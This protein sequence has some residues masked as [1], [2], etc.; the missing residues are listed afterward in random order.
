MGFFIMKNVLKVV[1]VIIG[2][3]I[4]AGFAS[5]QEVYLFFFSYGM[6]GLIGILISSIII[7]VVIY[8]TFNILN[9][10]KINTYKD[11]LNILI[12]K[13]TKLKIIANFIINIFIL[14]TF[15]IMIAG[16]GAYFEQEIGINR[17]VGSLILAIITFIVFM[18]SIKGV[19]KVNELIVPILIG[20]I[21]II[22]II[23]IKNIH[24]LNL[25]NYVI[26]TNYTNFALSAVL[27]SSYNSILLIPVLITLNNYVKNK[28]QIFYISFISAIVT[29]LLS[30][31]IFLLLVRVDVDI[32]KLEMPVVYVVSNMF[33]ILRYIY[34]VIILGSIFTT[35]IS[36]GVSFLQNTA[37]NKKGYTQISILMCITSVMISKF[38]FSNLVSL[39]YPIFGYL[40]LIQIL[41]LCVIKISKVTV[42]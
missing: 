40:G 6:K 9:K 25:E 8:S 2:T 30:V 20:F 23:S 4:G 3:L 33:K 26:R 41:R 39:L 10:Y 16:F 42:R 28:K 5:G 7:G 12:P 1:F 27:Y 35:A 37:K 11:F 22:G 21:F 17:L 15:F 13:N 38:G 19:V 31:I 18:T 36:L 14:I 29:I 24:I 32:S 34:G